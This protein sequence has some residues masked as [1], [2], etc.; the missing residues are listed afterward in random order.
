M[1]ITRWIKQTFGLVLMY[2][3]IRSLR[4]ISRSLRW[5]TATFK[6][7]KLA[8]V[9]DGAGNAWAHGGDAVVDASLYR[10]SERRRD[11]SAYERLY[12]MDPLRVLSINHKST[13]DALNLHAWVIVSKHKI[14]TT[15]FYTGF[16]EFI[17]L[18]QESDYDESYLDD[19]GTTG[20]TRAY[21]SFL[22][23]AKDEVRDVETVEEEV[24]TSSYTVNKGG[25]A[26]T[27]R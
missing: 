25:V 7:D 9:T 24:F 10:G 15:T 18:F 4:K 20:V 6:G 3:I 17:K 2:R 14:G 23:C 5:R 16:G 8:N 12:G 19:G 26:S 22:R 11:P 27:E 21:W 13:I 1:P